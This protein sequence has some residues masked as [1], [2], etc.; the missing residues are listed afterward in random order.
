MGIRKGGLTA[1]GGRGGGREFDLH[2]SITEIGIKGNKREG[3]KAKAGQTSFKSRRLRRRRLHL[4]QLNQFGS[5]IVG[6]HICTYVFTSGCVCRC[7][8]RTH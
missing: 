1:T 2:T 6:I 7:R 3:G 4:N 8:S 5:T